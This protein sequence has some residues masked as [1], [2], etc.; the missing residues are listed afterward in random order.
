MAHPNFVEKTFADGSKIVKLVNVFS[1]ES[2]Q[3]YGNLD[4]QP[5]VEN[6]GYWGTCLHDYLIDDYVIIFDSL[7]HALRE[8]VGKDVH[9]LVKEL[10]H[11]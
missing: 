5:K 2:F 7:L 8:V 9:Y 10:N 1:L 11:G 6:Q 3:L 4:I